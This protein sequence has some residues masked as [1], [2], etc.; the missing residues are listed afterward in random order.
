[1]NRNALNN[2]GAELIRLKLLKVTTS[3]KQEL[4]VNANI[5]IQRVSFDLTNKMYPKP[6]EL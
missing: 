5:E 4:R 6:K 1:M 3:N 2:I